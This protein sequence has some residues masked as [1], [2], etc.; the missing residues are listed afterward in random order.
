VPCP[1]THACCCRGACSST[2]VVVVFAVALTG[3]YHSPLL[4]LVFLDVVAV[5]LVASYRT[6]IKLALW[7][8]LLL[9]LA[10]A[11][12]DAGVFETTSPVVDDRIAI[13][14][15]ATFLL[16]AGCTALFSSVNERSLR[17]NRA[18]LESLVA[19]GAELERTRRGE[20]IMATLVTH[21]CGRLGFLR[22][23][24]LVRRDGRWEGVSD[25]GV[26]EVLLEIPDRSAPLV[27]ET[28]TAGAPKLVRSID[29][30]LL[31][32][33]VPAATNVV[34]VPVG[35]DGKDLGV[36]IGEWGGDSE[37][38][39]PML[40]VQ[41]FSQAA[42]HTALAL[43]NAELLGEVERLATRDA[44][45]GLANRRLFDESLRREAARSSRLGVPLS[46]LVMTST[47]SSR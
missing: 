8:A 5:T 34:I 15:A 47:T 4:F 6:G 3:G 2:A 41:A 16:F 9:L 39:I 35:A 13:V 11:A 37:A 42:M 33:V 22:A 29:D 17:N 27:W 40:T 1:S 26:A 18:Q 44:L 12:A 20:D 38:R 31:D 30:D 14:G 23:A 28:L 45:T 24:V 43:H 21:A 36:A 32:T 25:D 46:L 10:H 19:L 7:C